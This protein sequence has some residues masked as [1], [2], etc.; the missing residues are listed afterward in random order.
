MANVE[1]RNSQVE[2]VGKGTFYSDGSRFDCLVED[3]EIISA[4]GRFDI[5][6][7]GHS[8]T[9]KEDLIGNIGIDFAGGK[10]TVKGSV[11]Q[12]YGTLNLN[13]GTLEI[14][15]D[16]TLTT[17]G[18]FKM[19][20]DNDYFLIHGNFSSTTS[21]IHYYSNTNSSYYYL[22][23]GVMEVKGNMFSSST[24]PIR[25]SG[26]HK[27]I[28]S[29]EDKQT[30]QLNHGNSGSMATIVLTKWLWEGY[31]FIDTR[32]D[33]LQYIDNECGEYVYW[34][35]LTGGKLVISGNGAMFDYSNTSR[36]PWYEYRDQ[37]KEVIVGNGVTSIG[38][39][40][41]QN[42]KEL[43]KVTLS[44]SVTRIG[45]SAF[46]FCSALTEIDI[47][48][49]VTEVGS[50]AFYKC[51]SLSSITF[52]SKTTK[53]AGS[54]NTIPAMATIYAPE[55]SQALSYAKKFGRTCMEI[56][57]TEVEGTVGNL[58]WYLSS[59]GRLTISGKG[60]MPDYS[61]STRA[62]WYQYNARINE[63]VIGEGVTNVGAYAFQSMTQIASVTLSSTVT[64]IGVSAF[65]VCKA[66]VDMEL[67]K[68][69]ATVDSYAFYGCTNLKELRILGKNTAFSGSAATVPEIALIR[70][71]ENSKASEYA[72]KYNKTYLDLDAVAQ[73]SCGDSLKWKVT[74]DRELVIFGAGAMT[75]FSSAARAP[76]YN[77]YCNT[78]ESVTVREGVTTIGSYA[79]QNCKKITLVTLPSTL[80]SIGVSAF[81]LCSSL[82]EIEIPENVEMLGS[83]AFYKC[84]GMTDIRFLSVE[85]TITSSA[86]TIPETATIHC[87]AGSKA[88]K[89]AEKFARPVNR[90]IVVLAE[91]SCGEDVTWKYIS[92]GE[93]IISGKGAM[94][95]YASTR[96][97]P[98]YAYR[99]KIKT[100]TIEQGVTTVGD[101]AFYGCSAIT[102]AN[103]PQSA[104]SLG[105]SS[106]SLCSGLTEMTISTSVTEIG[107]YAFYKCTSMTDI[108]VLSSTTKITASANTIADKTVIH[109]Q[110]GSTA[111]AYAQKYGRTFVSEI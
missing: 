22:D 64:K 19:K 107:S 74:A 56:V 92:G 17:N 30:I 67:T 90:I 26:T 69:V 39:Y 62:P 76:W 49:R 20:D 63:L 45:V 16:Y 93:L 47:P 51:A 32:Y 71:Q 40:A 57:V 59:D 29:G 28:L 68:T 37:V 43:R 78:I 101:Y 89:Y 31:E 99:Y 108:T 83:Y 58:R 38:A 86:N 60:S 103:L 42:C 50:Y 4:V 18:M 5:N 110:E 1:I 84:T 100:V 54:A 15:G 44:S 21:G 95:D 55:K 109:G 48:A 46:A 75:D 11:E 81:S 52:N 23:A 70:G 14:Y 36:A 8:L 98:W 91:G 34:S 111:E 80:T 97:A 2:F 61:S 35:F 72:N 94:E 9:V 10:L 82:P 65:A 12:S 27:L 88:E 87:A 41:F 33:D 85:M 25:S 79:F 77:A 73:G 105:V 7:N 6:L 3:A 13:G 106:F 24:N 96:R 102:V 66:L 53:I 104:T